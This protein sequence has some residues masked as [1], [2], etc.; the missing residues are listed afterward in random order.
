MKS[1]VNCG[2]NKINQKHCQHLDCTVATYCVRVPLIILFEKQNTL[3]SVET[4]ITTYPLWG[5]SIPDSLNLEKN[6]GENSQL[7][8]HTGLSC[9]NC[10]TAC[11]PLSSRTSPAAIYFLKLQLNSLRNPLIFK[12]TLMQ[13]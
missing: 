5:C 8:P 10:F 6:S 12:G 7:C 13:I 4:F 9:P 2:P 11:M 1:V 3:F